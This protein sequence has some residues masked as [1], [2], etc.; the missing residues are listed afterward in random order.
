MANNYWENVYHSFLRMRR[1]SLLVWED[2]LY[3]SCVSLI[4]FSV[5]VNKHLRNMSF[6]SQ[7]PR[8]YTCKMGDSMSLI[9]FLFGNIASLTHPGYPTHPHAVTP[10]RNTRKTSDQTYRRVRWLQGE[11]WQFRLLALLVKLRARALDNGQSLQLSSV[12]YLWLSRRRGL[13]D[14]GLSS[15]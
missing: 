8:S 2:T 14:S 10:A 6:W 15:S 4:L 5:F 9:C 11:S 3:K 1:I 12:Q 7:I 13:T